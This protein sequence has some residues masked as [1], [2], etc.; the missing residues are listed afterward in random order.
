M[1]EFYSILLILTAY[2][3]G[4]IPTG[5]L[6]TRYHT[7]KNILKEGSGNVGST[8]VRRIAGR[9]V[10]FY[11]QIL[12]I[13]KGLVPVGAYLFFVDDINLN[14]SEY[15]VFLIALASIIGHDFS[16]FLGF[17]GGKGVNTTLGASLLLAPWAVL[18]GGGIYYV[19]KRSFQYVSLGS[20]ALSVS[21]PLTEYIVYGLSPVVYYLMACAS[22]IIILH[23]KN[24]QR[25]IAGKENR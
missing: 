23:R 25:L 3:L 2:L 6:L 1:A 17:K 13:L 11:T 8:N 14:I 24:I 22:L 7:G 15:L 21:L 20:I 4:A 12:D 16:V 10:S 19:V 9:R 18:I 5:Y